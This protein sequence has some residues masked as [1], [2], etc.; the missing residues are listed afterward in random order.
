MSAM[1]V[2]C[3]PQHKQIIVASDAASYDKQGTVALIGSKIHAMPWPA[4]IQGTGNAGA[5]EWF[6]ASAETRF[7]S[8]DDLVAGVEAELPSI[9]EH[10]YLPNWR[11]EAAISGWSFARQR[12]ETISTID[13][14]GPDSTPENDAMLRAS[15]RLR[16]GKLLVAPTVSSSPQPST[17]ITIRAN[18]EGISDSDDPEQ[19]KRMLR[20][21][22]EMQRHH[23]VARLRRHLVGGFVEIAVVKPDGVEKSIVHEWEEDRVGEKITPLPID[24]LAFR[25]QLGLPRGMTLIEQD[26][27][28]D[29]LASL[30]RQLAALQQPA[31]PVIPHG[32]S[33]MQRERMEKKARK[34]TLRVVS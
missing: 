3:L 33:R 15:G 25:E 10:V 8:F 4:V 6:V 19:V 5:I 32:L 29:Q 16:T 21:M 31:P 14:G 27:V 9:A 22:L 1:N 11:F 34:G 17:E 13:D 2:V 7:A 23:F 28:R 26:A 30:N 20:L 12:P 24:W 18:Y